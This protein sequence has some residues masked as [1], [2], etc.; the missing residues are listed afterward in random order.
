VAGS[1][2][3]FQVPIDSIE[4]EGLTVLDV[5]VL[6]YDLGDDE[7]AGLLGNDVLQHFQVD[8]DSIKGVLKLRKK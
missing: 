8:L 5:R 1:D 7:N 2:L 6:V 3:A 4:I